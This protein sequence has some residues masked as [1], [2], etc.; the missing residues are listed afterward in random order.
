[1][2]R[3]VLVLGDK[4][5]WLKVF[6]PRSGGIFIPTPT[7]PPIGSDVRIDLTIQTSDGG[8]RLVLKGSVQFSRPEGDGRGPA[9]CTVSLSGEDREKIN[10]INGFVRGGLI[11][12][13]EK[14]RLPLRLSV[15]Y[16][17]LDGPRQSV[18][19]DINEE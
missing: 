12:R 8:P 2:V 3:L 1:M 4:A 16:G 10:F 11:N 9:G 19:R 15:T 13:R 7:P 18:C 6:D 5:D 14:R 17:A